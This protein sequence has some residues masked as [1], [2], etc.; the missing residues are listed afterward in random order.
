MIHTTTQNHTNQTVQHLTH[1]PR[2]RTST[3]TG[4]SLTRVQITEA[5]A[6]SQGFLVKK[7]AV[8]MD[9][10]MPS[11]ILVRRPN[12]REFTVLHLVSKGDSHVQSKEGALP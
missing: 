12:E 7:N 1:L 3:P 5:M 11:G 2:T 10:L 4:R 6:I 9:G 8:V